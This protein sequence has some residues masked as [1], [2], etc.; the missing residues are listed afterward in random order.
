M[1]RL[2]PLRDL[3]APAAVSAYTRYGTW[4]ERQPLAE[5]TKASYLSLTRSYLGW[6]VTLDDYESLIPDHTTGV[7]GC[8]LGA[9]G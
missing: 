2:S 8:R 9:S 5:R 4:L 7:V 3:D 1:T 6:L